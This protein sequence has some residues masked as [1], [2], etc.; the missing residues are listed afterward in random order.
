MVRL[1]VARSGHSLPELVVALTLLT[2]TLGAISSSVLLAS[3][4]TAESV[5]RQR[6]ISAAETLLDS[7]TAIPELPVAGAR[8]WA[9]PPWLLEWEVE[10]G[11]GGDVA[12]LRVT[13]TT[14]TRGAPTARLRGLWIAPLPGPFP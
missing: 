1:S 13:A 10:P 9:G 3:R 7:L 5:G 12:T 4:W 2:A 14:T 8:L 11:P 6:A